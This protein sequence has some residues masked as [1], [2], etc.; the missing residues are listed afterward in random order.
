MEVAPTATHRPFLSR[1]EAQ[2][3]RTDYRLRDKKYVDH[4]TCIWHSRVKPLF[5]S[6]TRGW[7]PS[8]CRIPN[9]KHLDGA[10]A[11][12]LQW[13]S[14]A[15]NIS[16]NAGS[17]NISFSRNARLRIVQTGSSHRPRPPRYQ[18]LTAYSNNIYRV[19]RLLMLGHVF[20]REYG[21]SSNISDW[22]RLKSS[23]V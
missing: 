19:R 1:L 13:P 4:A 8:E 5:G 23:I 11:W 15:I 14:H 21:E 7:K 6:R 17:L 2:R 9:T 3:R 10:M 20:C 12:K 22:R 16:T 18:G